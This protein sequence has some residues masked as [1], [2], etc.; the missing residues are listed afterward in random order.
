MENENKNKTNEQDI[1]TQLKIME[2]DLSTLKNSVDELKNLNKS[3]IELV[4]NNYSLIEAVFDQNDVSLSRVK[5]R[6][7]S[8]LKIVYIC[9]FIIFI[10]I[11]IVVGSMIKIHLFK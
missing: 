9:V 3:T 4:H 10:I 2:K 5:N 11:L 1:V 7:N 6:I 8:S